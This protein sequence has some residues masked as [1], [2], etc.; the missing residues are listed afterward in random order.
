[1]KH[2]TKEARQIETDVVVVGG[3]GSGLAAAVEAST[4]GAAVMLV[5]KR[6]QL[7]GTT[8]LAVGSFTAACTS[9]QRAANV[10]DRT[11]WHQQD[12]AEFT[13]H[14]E[15]KNN[16]ALRAWLVD[17]AADTLEWLREMGVEF[18][19]PHPEPPNRLP[20]MHNVVPNAK[21]YIFRLQ[22]RALRQG[23][24]IL[25]GYEAVRLAKDANGRVT[26]MNVRSAEGESATIRARR[27]VILAAG[28]YSS[29]S[30]VK[31]EFL[32][33]GTAAIEGIN[34]HSTGDGHRLAREAGAA[35][36]NM[37]VIYGP[38][39]R[40]VPP[41]GDPFQQ[42][43]P[44]SGDEAAGRAFDALRPKA[45]QARAQELLFTWQHP[46][47]ALYEKGAI[48]VNRNGERFVD[49]TGNPAAAIPRQPGK[50]AYVVFDQAVTET[51]SAWPNF[52]STAPEIG[53]A[54][55]EDYR[56][57]RPDLYHEAPGVADL[58]S[59]LGISGDALSETIAAYNRSAAGAAQDR[60]GRP[61]SGHTVSRPPYYAL[62]PAKGWI[63]TTEGGVSVDE[64]MQALDAEGKVVPGLYAA[65]S[66]GMGGLI[67][68]SHGLHIAW[69]LT[70]GRQAGRHAAQRHPNQPS[71]DHKGAVRHEPSRH[72]KVSRPL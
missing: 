61:P 26:G 21:I 7:G 44:P 8:G 49:E 69:A 13:P 51:F 46:E 43:L 25:A 14:R 17:N 39:I 57:R 48:L 27:G 71:R 70:S 54:Y 15:P 41:P 32:E 50:V 56:L 31:A 37:D 45:V 12:I 1:M 9:L 29:G 4:H 66:N 65:G 36:V 53:Y 55:V 38:E 30:T 40:F 11:T 28:D 2:R 47:D 16:T 64:R 68:W 72:L 33:A 60:F 67:L 42:L 34:P 3:G 24:E 19:G 63:V 62:G 5:E 52:V 22:R 58:A 59:K 20:R 6:P 10:E 23:V 18:S 35:L